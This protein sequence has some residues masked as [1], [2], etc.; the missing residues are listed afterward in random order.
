MSL[1]S[2]SD[3]ELSIELKLNIVENAF[4]MNW[5]YVIQVYGR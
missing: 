1:V 5:V 4:N 2:L 3:F